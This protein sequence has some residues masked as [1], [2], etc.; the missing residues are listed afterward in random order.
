MELDLYS[1]FCANVSFKQICK[2]EFSVVNILNQ[3][4]DQETKPRIKEFIA[5]SCYNSTL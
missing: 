1:L 3:T 2:R 4:Q 5:R